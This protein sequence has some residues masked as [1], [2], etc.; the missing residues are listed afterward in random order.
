V[1][2]DNIFRELLREYTAAE[3]TAAEAYVTSY[4]GLGMAIRAGTEA[5][6]SG[7]QILADYRE[8]GGT[9]TDRNYWQLRH[10]V[11]SAASPPFGRDYAALLAGHDVM[12]VP[13]GREGLHQVN[14]RVFVQHDVSTG[15]PEHSVTNFSMTQREL[16]VPD[17]A[18]RMAEL[19]DTLDN[20][21][22]AYGRWIGFEITGVLRYTGS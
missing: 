5:G 1:P 22:D 10:A 14:F 18:S 16:D 9:V 3:G 4:A 15:L 11:L 7:R 20:P 12:E 13:G 21:A 6:L 2:D 8:V 19:M 17:A